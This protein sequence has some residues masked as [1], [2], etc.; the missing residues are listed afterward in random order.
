MTTLQPATVARAAKNLE[1][2]ANRTPVMTSR[3]L[4]GRVGG[5]VYLKCENFQRV[6]A[7]KFRGAYHAISQLSEERRAAGIITHSSGNHA[8]GVAL[9]ARLLGVQATVV[10]PEDAPAIKRKATEEYGAKI[11][12]CAAINREEVTKQLIDEHGFTLI[13]PYDNDH[14]IAG[15]GTSAW[16]LFDE[17]G[18][19]DLL[20]VPVGGGGLISGCA[21]ATAAKSPICQVIGVE[22]E[23]ADDANRSWREGRVIILDEVPVTIADGLRPR[24]IGQRNLDIMRRYVADM[25]TV[26]ERA[27]VDS[28]LFI[29]QRLKIVVETSA[30]VALAPLLSG[31]VEAKGRRIGIILSGGN[32]DLSE[33]WY[34]RY[35]KLT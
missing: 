33:L 28:L 25:T 23:L 9:A 20:F 34:H 19:L 10:M 22:P 11:V 12:P 15:Q 13:H 4:N 29:W 16:E 2:I 14:I 3:T 8:Q 35:P 31:T 5:Q 1:G 21:L 30:A 32:V 27:I 18:D 6:G 17:V 7:F 24:H 26:S